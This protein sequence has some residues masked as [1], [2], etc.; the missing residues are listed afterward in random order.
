MCPVWIPR[1]FR[2]E[3]PRRAEQR[4]RHGEAEVQHG[5]PERLAAPQT[6]KPAAQ[7]IEEQRRLAAETL[8][9]AGVLLGHVRR[10]RVG[11]AVDHD[12]P[13]RRIDILG[14]QENASG[15]AEPERE[16]RNTGELENF[17]RMHGYRAP[18]SI[19]RSM[20]CKTTFATT[21]SNAMNTAHRI[22]PNPQ[23]TPTAHEH[24][25]VAAVLMPRTVPPTCQI[26]PAQRKPTPVTTCPATRAGPVL[27]PISTPAITKAAAPRATSA[28]VCNPAGCL[29]TSRSRPIR[30]PSATADSSPTAWR[31]SSEN[32]PEA[33]MVP[34]RD[35]LRSHAALHDSHQLVGEQRGGKVERGKARSRC[36]LHDV[37]ADDAALARHRLEQAE[38][39]VPAQPA[40]HRRSG[41]RQD[42]RVDAVDVER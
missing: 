40:G 2:I 11:G 9:L 7:V 10:H 42:R 8:H 25:T 29:R 36:E 15:G 4:S 39:L 1:S 16:H 3:I 18:L 17:S 23:K 35:G 33:S 24:Q 26:S 27:S 14:Q 6:G 12:D 20:K 28:F 41:G 34:P 5:A 21:T 38:R 30:A 31:Q 32:I 13:V 22:M 37:E 19:R